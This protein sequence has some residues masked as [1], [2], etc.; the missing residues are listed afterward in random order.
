[1]LRSGAGRIG[2]A[3][4]AI[5]IALVLTMQGASPCPTH[6][7]HVAAELA[8]AT[9]PVAMTGIVA[10]THDGA[11]LAPHH[12]SHH[13]SHH[14]SHDLAHHTCTCVGCGCCVAMLDLC[15]PMRAFVPAPAA[16]ARA[17][18]VPLAPRAAAVGGADRRLPF[19]NGPPS[20]ADLPV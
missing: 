13:A 19:A 1:M 11:S 4:Y 9:M 18:V 12:A 2:M 16:V 15:A 8:N 6:D 10:M 17:T 20:G 5:W 14:G 7:P 3:C